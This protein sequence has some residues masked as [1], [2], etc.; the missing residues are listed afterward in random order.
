MSRRVALAI[1]SAGIFVLAAGSLASG[2]E[3]LSAIPLQAVPIPAG[4]LVAAVLYI[5]LAALTVFVTLSGTVARAIAWLLLAAAVLWLPVSIWLAGNVNL[6]FTAS[7]WRSELWMYYTVMAL[8]G[9]CLLLL[10]WELI[11]RAMPRSKR[12]VAEP[13]AATK[14]R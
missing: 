4:N 12:P 10:L 11:R 9:G 3:W 6:N 8:P 5:S 13:D 14:G 2:T 7:G 1:V